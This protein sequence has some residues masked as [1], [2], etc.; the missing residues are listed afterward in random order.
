MWKLR[1]ERGTMRIAHIIKVTRISGAERHLLFLVEGL[2]K[3][4]I[5]AYLIILVER[6]GPMD[7][8]AEAAE[9]RDIPLTRLTIQRDYDLSLLWRLRR[10]L[11]S[12]QP[13]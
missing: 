13:D 9:K 5:D 12:I 11:R 1:G 7:E 2:R 10:A 6:D 3:R 8:V 4:G